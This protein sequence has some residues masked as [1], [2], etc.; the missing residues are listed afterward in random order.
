MVYGS[1]ERRSR[2]DRHKVEFGSPYVLYVQKYNFTA[3]YE[4]SK[5]L[6]AYVYALRGLKIGHRFGVA[7]RNQNVHRQVAPSG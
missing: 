7:P 4:R 5:K 2:F 6:F 3:I 1:G